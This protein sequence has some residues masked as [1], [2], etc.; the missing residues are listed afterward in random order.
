MQSTTNSI[1]SSE[2]LASHSIRANHQLISDIIRI[3]DAVEASNEHMPGLSGLIKKDG[4]I[5]RANRQTASALNYAGENMFGVSLSE[6]I[7]VESW[8]LLSFA[9]TNHGSHT[10]AE[11]SAIDTAIEAPIETPQGKRVFLWKFRPFTWVSA[12]RGEIYS[13]HATDIT[14]RKN[15]EQKVA[16]FFSSIPLGIVTVGSDRKISW[17]YSAFAEI[18]LDRKSLE[19]V[20]AEDAIFGKAK[21][22]MTSDQIAGI[23]IFLDMIGSD[24]IWFD[25]NKQALPQEIGFSRDGAKEPDFWLAIMYSPIVEDGIIRSFLLILED[26]TERVLKRQTQSNA[27]SKEQLI[28]EIIL[29]LESA[30]A[31]LIATC[32]VDLQSLFADLNK[33]ESNGSPV[34]SVCNT[35]H[36]IKGVSRIMN[37]RDFK[38]RVH[39][40]ED[41][42]LGNE[43][44]LDAPLQP[45]MIA[46]LH[47]LHASWLE[48]SRYINVFKSP[49]KNVRAIDSESHGRLMEKRNLIESRLKEMIPLLPPEVAQ[50]MTFLTREVSSLGREPLSH[51]EPKL[52]NWFEQTAKKL[53]K[54]AKLSFKW[55]DA[56]IEPMHAQALSEVFMHLINNALDHGI[57]PAELRAEIQKNETASVT[58]TATPVEQGVF[59]RFEDDGRGMNREALYK[60]ALGRGLNLDRSKM[61]DD[62]ILLLAL[63]PGLTT[64]DQ[65]TD[66]SGRGI[67]LDAIDEKI[68]SFGGHGLKIAWSGVGLGTRFEF[69]LVQ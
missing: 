1:M 60:K 4:T 36:G 49:D 43:A 9:I 5:I 28:A 46:E 39:D 24:P 10:P 6:K 34:R 7:S 29:D 19:G 40:L 31:P 68:K 32:S 59:F 26:V 55:K 62:D 18:L 58:I 53:G 52:A 30:G 63:L 65:V 66:T 64:K 23:H 13:F 42:F 12:R 15:F 8:K 3:K 56:F 16:S 17:P 21:P 20:S 69:L 54:Q 48:I 27:K 38:E 41:R 57:E 44:G 47:A 33:H 61:S 2:E 11:M 37:L 35:L 45:W 14:E 25:V 67:G 22:F 50:Q 51:L